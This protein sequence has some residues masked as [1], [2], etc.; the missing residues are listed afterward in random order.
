LKGRLDWVTPTVTLDIKTFTQKRGKSIDQSVAD[1]IYYEGYHAQAYR[2]AMLRGWPKWDGKHVVAFV[3]SDPPHEVRLRSLGPK[4][5]GQANL[6]WTTAQ[7]QTRQLIRLYK[8]CMDHFGKD[9]PWRY[10]QEID[11]LL[12]EEMKGLVFG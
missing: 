2:Y 10:A 3:E 5:D 6:Y 9:Q 1:A 8:K 11:P 4:S 7:M 12:D